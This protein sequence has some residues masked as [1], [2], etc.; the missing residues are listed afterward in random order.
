MEGNID[1]ILGDYCEECSPKLVS[2]V[3]YVR[4]L[5]NAQ[6]AAKEALDTLVWANEK[7][8]KKMEDLR[9]RADGE[10][11]ENIKAKMLTIHN[12]E[13]RMINRDKLV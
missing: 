6:I 4:Q 7:L 1:P 12:S 10:E 13:Q 5:E 8:T 9:E 3:G 11:K 2:L